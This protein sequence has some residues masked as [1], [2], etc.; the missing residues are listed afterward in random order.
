MTLDL[1]VCVYRETN[2]KGGVMERRPTCNVTEGLNYKAID[3]ICG[4]CKKESKIVEYVEKDDQWKC[5]DCLK[6]E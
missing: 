5:L 2:L 4:V 6:E 3:L 1:C